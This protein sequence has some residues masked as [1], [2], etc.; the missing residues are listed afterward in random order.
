MSDSPGLSFFPTYS[1]WFFCI[2]S[3]IF[4]PLQYI[5]EYFAF[6]AAVSLSPAQDTLQSQL[7]PI[8]GLAKFAVGRG[9]A[10]LEPWL[11]DCSP[12]SYHWATFP[13][14][15]I[16]PREPFLYLHLPSLSVCHSRSV[17]IPSSLST[18]SICLCKYVSPNFDLS[19][20]LSVP[21]YVYQFTSLNRY[22]VYL[23]P[24]LSVVYILYCMSIFLL[25]CWCI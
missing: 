22:T 19:F 15:S 8:E 2:Y 9:V 6:F 16:S 17:L 23:F 13:T 24:C 10:G 5:R 14:S 21:R 3:N 4:S 11:L 7:E 20:Y 1:R 25:V 18:Y 12:V